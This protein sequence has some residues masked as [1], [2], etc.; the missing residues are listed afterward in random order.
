MAELG[1]QSKVSHSW[2]SIFPTLSQP[3]GLSLAF[4]KALRSQSWLPPAGREFLP[5]LGATVKEERVP[6]A[7]RV[8]YAESQSMFLFSSLMGMACTL[9]W[10]WGGGGDYENQ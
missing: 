4:F 9:G 2:S 7:R 10:G 1:P 3:P 8:D 5:V 6:E